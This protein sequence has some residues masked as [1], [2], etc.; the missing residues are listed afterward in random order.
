MP[1]AVSQ[2]QRA[3]AFGAKGEKWAKAHSFDNAG[4][5]PKVSKTKSARKARNKKARTKKKK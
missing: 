3:W 2:K 4:K 5:L 1:K